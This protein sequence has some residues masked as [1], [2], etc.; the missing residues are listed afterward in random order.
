M[1]SDRNSFVTA[2][3]RARLHG[4][5]VFSDSIAESLAVRSCLD[6]LNTLYGPKWDHRDAYK[7]YDMVQP[8]WQ[9]SNGQA[10]CGGHETNET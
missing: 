3:M 6:D 1:H 4:G 9:F 2:I 5:A 8:C 10:G 7:Y